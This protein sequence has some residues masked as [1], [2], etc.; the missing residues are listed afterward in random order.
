MHP[1]KPRRVSHIFTEIMIALSKFP[2]FRPLRPWWGGDLQTIR[3]VVMR[4]R[5]DLSP[6]PGHRL[7]VELADGDRLFAMLHEPSVAAKGPTLLLLHG[8][9][10]CE[11]SLYMRA[12]TAFFLRRGWRVIRLNLR[13][14][15][16]SAPHC[17]GSY[18]AGRSEDLRA[19]L[20]WLARENSAA[21][22]DGVLL[23]GFS[24]GA[25]LVL[26]FLAEGDFPLPVPAAVS[27][28]APID[29]QGAW[30]TIQRPRNAFYHRYLLSSL[31]REFRQWPVKLSA[32]LKRKVLE[33]RSI[34]RFDEIWT[35]PRN[36]FS[37]A[38]DYYNRCSTAGRLEDIQVPALLIHAMDDPWIPPAP[39]LAAR[40]RLKSP[41]RILLSP[42][43]GHVGFHAADDP[44]PWH[45]RC[46]EVFFREVVPVAVSRD[47]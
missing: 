42:S 46:A 5:T 16:P 32:D 8:L 21:T 6:W 20:S 22:R 40:R 17:Q 13:G 27:V 10:G 45:D 35:A 30:Q 14:A 28:S 18:H 23:M 31:H 15:G 1:F 4:R 3:N 41:L 38:D 43:G 34:Y 44:Q 7:Q 47:A 37:S 2:T 11:D 26:K 12:S 24:L 39:Y 29:L 25:N 33:A 9:T 36:G 19:F